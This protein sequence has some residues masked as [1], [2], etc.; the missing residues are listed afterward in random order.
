MQLSNFQDAFAAA[1]RGDSTDLVT[2]SGASGAPAPVPAWLSQVMDQPG[3][4][5][6]RNSGRK[7]SIDALRANYPSIE[8]LV[9]EAWF[10]GA[11]QT[12]VSA[13]PPVD[14]RLMDYGDA[15]ADFLHDFAPA[16]ELPYLSG[17][18]ALD[19][20]WTQAHLAAD[21]CVL[22]PEWMASL[23]PEQFALARLEPHPA[24]QWRW[25]AAHPA[26]TI[27]SRQRAQQSLSDPIDWQ[28]EGGLLTRPEGAVQWCALPA[29]GVEFLDACAAGASLADAAASAIKGGNASPAHPD[30]A[31]VPLASLMAL[32][33]NAGA[34][35]AAVPTR[36]AEPL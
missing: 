3:F 10:H 35:R 27:W 18:A 21:A 29:S 28:A 32:L 34:L 9:G 36:P 19:R 12:Y 1:I 11:A 14:G 20:A 6:Y 4:A 26:Y 5:V 7:A 17:V 16:Q 22:A 33:L 25:C 24:A 30:D 2:A 31:L 23:T 8:A 13:C 15:F